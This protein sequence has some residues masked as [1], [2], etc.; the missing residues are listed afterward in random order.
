VLAVGL[1]AAAGALSDLGG[2]ETKTVAVADAGALLAAQALAG[3]F[4]VL[5]ATLP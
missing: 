2:A 5:S 1:I 4:F 3:E